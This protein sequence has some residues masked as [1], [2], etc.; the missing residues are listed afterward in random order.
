MAPPLPRL[1]ADIKTE[2]PDDDEITILSSNIE[3]KSERRKQKKEKARRQREKMLSYVLE[4]LEKRR[5]DPNPPAHVAPRIKP[6]PNLHDRPS[7]II[8]TRKIRSPDPL[9]YGS[10]R[11]LTPP[12]SSS[13]ASSP[14]CTRAWLEHEVATLKQHQL[15][16]RHPLRGQGSRPRGRQ[17]QKFNRPPV[18]YQD[19][20]PARDAVRGRGISKK[21]R[22][23]KGQKRRLTEAEQ[24]HY[25]EQNAAILSVHSQRK[26]TG[27]VPKIDRFG[28]I[29]FQ[30]SDSPIHN[31]HVSNDNQMD[32]DPAT[33]PRH[34]RD[35][36][37]RPETDENQ[38]QRRP[39]SERLGRPMRPTYPSLSSSSSPSSSD[40]DSPPS[41]PNQK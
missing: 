28:Y 29:P 7:T 24:I 34:P 40:S 19:Q 11:S 14:L 32:V 26:H 39:I 12:P 31:P 6:P 5:P 35:E 21:S 13:R 30:P 4:H 22:P 16:S 3:S 25:R 8:P 1:P 37:A 41:R 9:V 33:P 38:Q 23:Y 10:V 36:R 17:S 18:F 20:Y 2:R 15:R 27:A